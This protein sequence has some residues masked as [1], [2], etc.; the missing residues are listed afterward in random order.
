MTS[1]QEV[2]IIHHSDPD[3]FCSGAIV[4]SKHPKAF[5]IPFYY[6]VDFY[7]LERIPDGS[8]IYI[9]DASLPEHIMRK[10]MKR[11]EIVW[12]D[13]H[14]TAI[15][16]VL[17]IPEI[18]TLPGKRVVGTAACELTW[19]YLYPELPIPRAV[20]LIG[21]FDVHRKEDWPDAPTFNLF[22]YGNDYRLTDTNME[23]WLE[24]LNLKDVGDY[25][26]LISEILAKWSLV[27][28]Y[29]KMNNTISARAITYEAYMDG[30]KCIV[31]N[32]S[33]I[34]SEYFEGVMREDHELMVAWHVN[35]RGMVKYSVF[36]DRTNIHV[37]KLLKKLVTGQKSWSGGG[38]AGAGGM[39]CNKIL[40][41]KTEFIKL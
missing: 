15:E 34:G 16:E 18:F 10:L 25:E 19:L 3:G 27:Y 12:I 40:L 29:Y 11:C 22:M 7:H 13:H 41:P 37:G 6:E 9:V 4:K 2:F 23:K 38:H 24:L 28:D 1:T 14:D 30:H 20:T 8:L 32:R 33:Q 26:Y 21:S 39:V 35:K 31:A 17:H 5:L 36:T